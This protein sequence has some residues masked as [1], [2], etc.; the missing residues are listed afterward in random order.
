MSGRGPGTSGWV[1]PASRNRE[2]ILRNESAGYGLFAW[3]RSEP[4][5][6]CS[7]PTQRIQSTSVSISQLWKLDS[8]SY[9]QSECSIRAPSSTIRFTSSFEASMTK[10][11][12][13]TIIRRTPAS[14]AASNTARIERGGMC[15]EARMAS[16]SAIM[17]RISPTSGRSS[18]LPSRKT[19]TGSSGI[20]STASW[21]N[22]SAGCSR[23]CSMCFGEA[24][25]GNQT[26]FP[27]IASD[28]FTACGL[29]PPTWVLSAIPPKTSI[30]LSSIPWPR[31]AATSVEVSWW[32]DLTTIARIPAS[33]ARCAASAASIRRGNG[34]G[35]GWTWRSTAPSRI[36]STTSRLMPPPPRHRLR[37]RHQDVRAL[38]ARP[39]APLAD[40]L[41][42]SRCHLE[43]LE[44]IAH[45]PVRVVGLD[46]RLRVDGERAAHREPVHDLDRLR[47]AELDEVLVLVLRERFRIAGEELHE[48]AV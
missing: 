11:G 5:E 42:P 19:S 26:I 14:R 13:L 40:A 35:Y 47:A 32:C 44:P 15:P 33:A 23:W 25:V 48:L 46:A 9:M 41:E 43:R 31:S 1:I 6:E 28:M 3:P 36:R 29:R 2:Q 17:R 8:S 22:F 37:C 12:W 24:M 30:P 20:R 21:G 4:S 27:P 39:S 7:G 38:P 18:S 10:F 34:D 16:A 45:D